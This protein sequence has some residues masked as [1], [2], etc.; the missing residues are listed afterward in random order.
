MHQQGMFVDASLVPSGQR[1]GGLPRVIAKSKSCLKLIDAAF[2]PEIENAEVAAKFKLC[3]CCEELL[4]ER[5][6]ESESPAAN[7]RR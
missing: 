4:S 6:R 1:S 7:A 3:C 2:L 5:F